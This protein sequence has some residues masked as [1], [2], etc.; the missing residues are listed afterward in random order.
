MEDQIQH[1][2]HYEYLVKL[3]GSPQAHILRISTFDMASSPDR[4]Y[5]RNRFDQWR[6][7]VIPELKESS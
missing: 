2:P 1:G 5:S 7:T 6:K 3:R 4:N